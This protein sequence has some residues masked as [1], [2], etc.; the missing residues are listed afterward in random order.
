MRSFGYSTQSRLLVLVAVLALSVGPAFAAVIVAPPVISGSGPYVWGYDTALDGSL[1]G[2]TVKPA[3]PSNEQGTLIIYDFAGYI[4]GTEFAPA[5]WTFIGA[6]VG[7]AI[8]GVTPGTIVPGVDNPGVVNLAWQ[9]TGVAIVNAGP[10]NLALG[11][12]GAQ[13]VFGDP[14]PT[15]YAAQDYQNLPQTRAFNSS[16]TFAPIP[17]PGALMLLAGVFGALAL[18][19]R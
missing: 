15:E 14:T 17:E 12:F 11:R 16:G 4:P 9:Y 5:G 19:R 3:P 7:P 13:S 18:R 10:A 8:A 1:G 2:F 6:N